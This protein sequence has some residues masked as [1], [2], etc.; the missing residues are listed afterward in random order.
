MENCMLDGKQCTITWYVDNTKIFH[1]DPNEI[2][3]VTEQIEAVFNNMTV[4]RGKGY[5]LLGMHVQFRGNKE[6]ISMKSYLV[7]AI[8][9][10][11]LCIEKEAATC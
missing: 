6:V 9:E 11:G 5:T 1:A 7:E 8:K 3:K 2:T 10:S 4:T